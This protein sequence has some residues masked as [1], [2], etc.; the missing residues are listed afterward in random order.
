MGWWVADD[1]KAVLIEHTHK[2]LH[3]T[4]APARGGTPYSSAELL[5]GGTKR[6]ERMLASCFV[7][8]HGR[9]YLEIEAG[10]PEIGPTYRLY[11]VVESSAG[12]PLG[13]GEYSRFRIAKDSVLVDDLILVPNTSIGL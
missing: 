7:D 8:E 13:T 12:H 2:K 5:R 6:I 9:R 4:V 11:P 3:V 10:T 1:G